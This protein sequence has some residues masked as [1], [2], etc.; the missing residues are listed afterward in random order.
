M[1]RALAVRRV[2]D[3]RGIVMVPSRATDAVL[4]GLLRAYVE[5][6]GPEGLLV[7]HKQPFTRAQLER[8]FKVPRGTNL[9]RRG[10]LYW[11]LP[12]WR[13]RRAM[14]ALM[15]E[16]GMRNSEVAGPFSQRSLRRANL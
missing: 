2:H 4:R 6:H 9:P 5:E 14:F 11:E 16:T 15:A 10:I 13:A 8:L 3:T 1:N 12:I 7:R